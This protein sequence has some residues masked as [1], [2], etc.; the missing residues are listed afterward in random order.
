[1]TVNTVI[2]SCSLVS[3]CCEL[4]SGWVVILLSIEILLAIPSWQES[5]S[6]RRWKRPYTSCSDITFVFLGRLRGK[7]VLLI[8]AH[9]SMESQASFARVSFALNHL[10]WAVLQFWVTLSTET[11]FWFKSLSH[12][13]T[14]YKWG[15]RS[16]SLGSLNMLLLIQ[17]SV[18]WWC[19]WN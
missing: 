15:T 14:R 6:H 17:H 9:C 13:T 16:F 1:M 12:W 2:I 5:Q 7:S 18:V 10:R 3:W 11:L 19:P 8:V 4:G